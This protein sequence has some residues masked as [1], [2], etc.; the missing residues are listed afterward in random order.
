MRNRTKASKKHRSVSPPVITRPDTLPLRDSQLDW[1][2][3]EGFIRHLIRL[4]PGVQDVKRYGKSGS[5]QKGIDL[6]AT[7]DNGDR[8]VFQCKQYSSYKLADAKKAVAKATYAANKY[9]LVIACQTD[10][11]VHDYIEA[12]K[13]WELWDVERVSD[14]VLKLPRESACELVARF[15]GADWCKAFLGIGGSSPFLPW[16]LF[17]A[18]WLD[19]DRLFNHNWQ[20]V[21]RSELVSSLD[22][23]CGDEHKRVALLVGRGGIG[24]SKLLHAFAEQFS[25]KRPKRLLRFVEENI[26]LTQ[27]SVDDL[28]EGPTPPSNSGFSTWSASARPPPKMSSLL[29]LPGPVGVERYPS[30]RGCLAFQSGDDPHRRDSS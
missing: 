20:L 28:P 1:S 30:G 26:P 19:Q 13:N 23:F 11:M 21:G 8:W 24:K 3:F 27:Q 25:A 5:K 7:L 4:L 29:R 15:F 17:F 22:R 6:I 18:R 2:R 14:E 9:F 10:S 16:K 12:Q